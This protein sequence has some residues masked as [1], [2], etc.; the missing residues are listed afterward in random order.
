MSR[1]TKTLSVFMSGIA[2]TGTKVEAEQERQL[3]PF[4][5]SPDPISLRPLNMP[6][7]NMYAAH[8]SHSSHSSHRSSSGG[9]SAP[10]SSGV[11]SPPRS[12]GTYSAPSYNTAVPSAERS[13]PVDPGR[14]ATV[15][16]KDI[17][18]SDRA[19][20]ELIKKVQMAL[21]I[22]G[23]D[24]GAIDG[25]FGSS[26]KRALMHFQ[27]DNGLIVDGLMNTATLNSL[28]VRAQ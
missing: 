14:A 8:R 18:P 20:I 24:P 19:L 2:L 3:D 5:S 6:G 23:Y 27:V 13:Q 17:D 16:P 1:F 12:S 15:T 28:G 25:L 21:L 10:R 11:Y 4:A 22:K 26:T 7:E 9:Y